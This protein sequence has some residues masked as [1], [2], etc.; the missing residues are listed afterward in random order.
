M[1][2]VALNAFDQSSRAYRLGNTVYS[3]IPRREDLS[4]STRVGTFCVGTSVSD[5]IA[6]RLLRNEISGN[7]ELL[8]VSKEHT[9]SRTVRAVFRDVL[10]EVAT[11]RNVPVFYYPQ[12]ELPTLRTVHGEVTRLA[13]RDV[14]LLHNVFGHSITSHSVPSAAAL[15]A[16]IARALDYVTQTIRCF[17]EGVQTPA[18]PRHMPRLRLVKDILTQASDRARFPINT[19]ND[20]RVL[21]DYLRARVALDDL[22]I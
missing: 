2:A 19:E 3:T 6:G 11:A 10:I 20:R 12:H 16:R 1:R 21:L 5:Y 7:L 17:T 13:S 15:R 22:S 14:L 4:K 9:R 8:V 18:E